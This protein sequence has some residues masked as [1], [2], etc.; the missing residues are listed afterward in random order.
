MYRIKMKG[1]V[2]GPMSEEQFDKI[3][4]STELTGGELYQKDTS[5][6]WKP[7][8]DILDSGEG[9][10]TLFLKLDK[11]E[12]E[13]L[14]EKGEK[15]GFI[16]DIL[17]EQNIEFRVDNKDNDNQLGKQ[18]RFDDTEGDEEEDKLSQTIIIKTPKHRSGK[19]KTDVR[20]LPEKEKRELDK[21]NLE[22]KEKKCRQSGRLKRKKRKRGK[23][24]IS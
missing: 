12:K 3:L 16:D 15:L 23:R 18:E 20:I 10:N 5:E 13:V 22:R 17:R 14:K 8:S 1:T 6:D 7:I 19:D 4:A 9:D 24:V 21:L 11:V 2:F